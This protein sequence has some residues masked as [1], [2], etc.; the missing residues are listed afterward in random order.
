MG[1]TPK[2]ISA[3][4]GAA[5]LGMSEWATPVSTWLKIMEEREPGFCEANN[6]TLPVWKDSAPARWGLAFED[7]ICELVGD[8][9]GV[10]VIC[11]EK[12]FQHSDYDFITCHIDGATG[13]GYQPTL[14]ENKTT[15]I[16]SYRDK[17]GEPGTDHIPGNYQIQVQ[18]QMMCTGL[19]ECV[20]SVLVFPNMVDE[21]EKAG[22]MTAERL[23]PDGDESNEH[24]I[25]SGNIS[26]D[27]LTMARWLNQM[28]YFHQYPV[29]ANPELQA[30]MLGGYLEF[31]NTNVLG[32]VPPTPK[33]YDDIKALVKEPKGTIVASE[34]EWRW[35][36]EYK[37]IGEEIS[38]ANK[39]RAQ[40]KAKLLAS[41]KAGAPHPI[42][43]ES[44]EK[45]IL[46]SSD[47]KKLVSWNGKTF[48]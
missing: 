32:S 5:V 25:N 27:I 14:V 28:G 21:W 33:T 42:D 3:S 23:W 34:Q 36:K 44:V 24:V 38:A 8:K 17:W 2:D 37:D 6:Y 43:D 47:G 35:A 9:S 13:P 26:L 31:W 4:R 46:R 22:L 18:H 10:P 41:M 19:D 20:V 48:R 30:K 7:A 16:R 29:K 45:W 11:R 12:E 39:R 40:L 15:N 1:A